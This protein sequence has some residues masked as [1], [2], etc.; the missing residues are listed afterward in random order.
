MP[1]HHPTIRPTFLQLTAAAPL[2]NPTLTS[3]PSLPAKPPTPPPPRRQK[4][5]EI[6]SILEA[7]YVP[8][9]KESRG[10]PHFTPLTAHCHPAYQVSMNSEDTPPLTK[11]GV[12]SFTCP[13]LTRRSPATYPPASIP[14][15]DAPPDIEPSALLSSRIF[16]NPRDF[17]P[18]PH[19]GWP[20]SLNFT[21]DPSPRL[22]TPCQPGPCRLP[23][24]FRQRERF[25]HS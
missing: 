13:S 19:D 23:P 18:T 20:G 16:L 12:S 15:T 4:P 14:P 9:A 5:H 8:I 2:T 21:V 6:P 10:K 3:S 1:Y 7:L 25:S 24:D 11:L 17:L 22:P